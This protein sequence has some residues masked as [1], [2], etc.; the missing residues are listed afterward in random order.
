M[1]W[2]SAMSPLPHEGWQ[3][4]LAAHDVAVVFIWAEWYV[5]TRAMD[6]ELQVVR[7]E[8]ETVAFF[9]CDLDSQP[10]VTADVTGGMASNPM[11]ACF[12]NGQRHDI[13]FGYLNP[14]KL[15]AKLREWLA[16]ST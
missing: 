1:N 2:T 9:G 14:E 3:Q 5:L 4:V 10:Q 6:K 8:F 12:F 11:L 7:S 16:A 15:R 13:S